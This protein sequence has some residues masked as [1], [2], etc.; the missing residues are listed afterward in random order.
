MSWSS[1]IKDFIQ[2][3][4]RL[5]SRVEKNSEDITSIRQ[6]LDKLARIL[7]QVAHTVRDNEAQISENEVKAKA[8]HN[9]AK[10]ERE[11]LIL[12]LENELLKLENRLK[13]AAPTPIESQSMTQPQLFENNN[14]NPDSKD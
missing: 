1:D 7:N 3:L 9:S 4:L 13:T 8:R 5:Q 11:N 6:D 12:R 10:L 2:K 14:N